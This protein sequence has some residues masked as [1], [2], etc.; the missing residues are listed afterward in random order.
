M[1]TNATEKILKRLSYFTEVP[2]VKEAVAANLITPLYILEKLSR[3]KSKYV[4][5]EV[6]KNPNVSL[7]ILKKL[8]EDK[9]E[10]VRVAVLENPIST[11]EMLEKF[12]KDKSEHVRFAVAID[13]RTPGKILENLS[14]NDDEDLYVIAAIT[15]NPNTLPETLD[16]L[17]NYPSYIVKNNVCQNIRTPKKTLE[18]LLNDDNPNIRGHAEC[19]LDVILALEEM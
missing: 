18:R 3:D 6:A 8:A 4:R 15:E 16:Y 9:E 7:D 1:N 14:R 11:M 13:E 2:K 19:A 17:S 10:D 12:S 5:C